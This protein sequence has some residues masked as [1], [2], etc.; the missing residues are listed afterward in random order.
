MGT[1]AE[2]EA[3]NSGGSGMVVNLP[4]NSINSLSSS[5]VINRINLF[6]SLGNVK[7]LLDQHNTFFVNNQICLIF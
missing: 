5:E 7:L 2:L 1:K 4:H 3:S 6:T